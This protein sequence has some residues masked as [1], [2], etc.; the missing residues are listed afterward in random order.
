LPGTAVVNDIP[1]S[2]E[3]VSEASVCAGVA[4]PISETI[5]V[6]PTAVNDQATSGPP[7]PDSEATPLMDTAT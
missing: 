2:T 3:A 1:S 7:T 5:V 4:P 6:E